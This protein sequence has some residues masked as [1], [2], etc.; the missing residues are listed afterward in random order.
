MSINATNV[1]ATEGS[2]ALQGVAIKLGTA[3]SLSRSITALIRGEASVIKGRRSVAENFN[4]GFAHQWWDKNHP[5][6][7]KVAP[8]FKAILDGLRS[9]GHSNPSVAWSEIVLYAKQARGIVDAQTEKAAA[10]AAKQ[11]GKGK[12]EGKDNPEGVAVTATPHQV[13]VVKLTELQRFLSGQAELDD[14]L[15]GVLE[16]VELSLQSLGADMRAEL[17]KAA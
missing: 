9:I 15:K 5:E 10:K 4:A 17:P 8:Y 13:A 6:W 2:P 1:S 12:T 7:V 3:E 14:T 16:F 11:K